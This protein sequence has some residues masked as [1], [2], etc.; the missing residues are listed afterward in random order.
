MMNDKALPLTPL[1]GG[2]PREFLKRRGIEHLDLSERDATHL[3]Y[4]LTG[5]VLTTPANSSPITALVWL[6]SALTASGRYQAPES[7]GH[8][9]DLRDG[10]PPVDSVVLMA[11][12][13]RHFLTAPHRSGPTTGSPRISTS[14]RRTSSAR[15][16]RWTQSPRS[17][18]ARPIRRAVVGAMTAD[19]AQVTADLA[20]YRCH[21][22]DPWPRIGDHSQGAT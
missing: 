14:Q 5:F 10:G 6:T 12:V 3:A 15:S 22:A 8:P 21:G 7:L 2:S 13:Q 1:T 18:D 17:L 20:T 19:P 4:V 9:A 16:M 11:V